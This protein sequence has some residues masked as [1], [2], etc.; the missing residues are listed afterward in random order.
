MDPVRVIIYYLL[1]KKMEYN[2]FKP[3]MN[4][5]KTPCI[6]K[7]LTNRS[8][9]A[10]NHLIIKFEPEKNFARNCSFQKGEN[11]FIVV[12]VDMKKSSPTIQLHSIIIIIDSLRPGPD[13]FRFDRK[14]LWSRIKFNLFGWMFAY[15][16]RLL[17]HFVF[18]FFFLCF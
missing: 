1:Q 6:T 5:Q 14:Y 2:I 9:K 10:I 11:A 18:N 13:H 3:K 15:I 7:K 12:D 8:L 17:F 16:V 4:T